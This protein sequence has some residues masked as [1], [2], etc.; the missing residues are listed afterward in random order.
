MPTKNP[1]IKAEMARIRDLVWKLPQ[2]ESRDIQTFF[3]SRQLP[4][5]L[6]GRMDDEGFH[7]RYTCSAI[8]GGVRVTCVSRFKITAVTTVDD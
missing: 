7:R 1:I 4:C 6:P 8:P 3:S 5:R 2:D